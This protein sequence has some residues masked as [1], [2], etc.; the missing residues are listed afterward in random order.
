MSERETELLQVAPLGDGPLSDGR[1]AQVLSEA[2]RAMRFTGKT[3]LDFARRCGVNPNQIRVL[4][5]GQGKLAGT[6]ED[7]LY[8]QLNAWAAEVCR[9]R[10]TQRASGR[11][12]MLAPAA[13][14]RK[15][16]RSCRALSDL[17]VAFGPPGIGKTEAA[18]FVAGELNAVYVRV[19]SDCRQ[20]RG[21]RR[22]VAGAVRGR[23]PLIGPVS[24]AVLS[25][26]LRDCGRMLIVDQAHDLAD[27]ALR[28]VMDIYD[29]ANAPILL[30]GTVALVRR[31]SPEADLL[32]GQL[33]SRVGLRVD[34]LPEL[35]LSG[36]DDDGGRAAQ[37]ISAD[38]LRQ[39]FETPRLRI[40]PEAM[41]M[42]L[43][44]A[45]SAVGLLRVAAKMVAKAGVFARQRAGEDELATIT[46]AD[47]DRAG[48]LV[49]GAVA[50]E[51]VHAAAAVRE[52][53]A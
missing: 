48:A 12:I 10:T 23:G 3:Q 31:V 41:R 1:K 50:G 40:A 51:P 43:R 15:A 52:G 39:I 18:R 33:S 47:L 36:G 13:R 37:W 28:V 4:F 5:N 44:V 22:A 11:F 38:E 30:I 17:G 49:G 34:L 24:T 9:E 21:F 6:T 35:R 20:A 19:G 2:A 46:V 45:N 53:V 26:S 25:E 8:R 7:R 29:E 32:F 16:A 27:D 14:L 42:L